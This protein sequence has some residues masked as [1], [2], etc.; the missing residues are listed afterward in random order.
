MI[1]LLLRVLLPGVERFED[2]V[3]VAPVTH[4]TALLHA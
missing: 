4:V 2:D 1:P 3:E